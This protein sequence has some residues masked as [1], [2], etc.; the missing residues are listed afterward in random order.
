[1]A[2]GLPT[3][4]EITSKTAYIVYTIQIGILDHPYAM[5]K[6]VIIMTIFMMLL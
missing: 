6:M 3:S 1:M 5:F 2:M 4:I